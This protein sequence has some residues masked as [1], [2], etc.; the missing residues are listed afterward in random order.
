MAERKAYATH[1]REAAEKRAE[2]RVKPSIDPRTGDVVFEAQ[3]HGLSSTAEVYYC[4]GHMVLPRP[5]SEGL[6]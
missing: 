3:L 6:T 4:N 2:V 5:N 1:L